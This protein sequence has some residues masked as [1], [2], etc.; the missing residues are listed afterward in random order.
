M[1]RYAYICPTKNLLMKILLPFLLIL[2]LAS[3]GASDS[4]ANAGGNSEGSGQ[5]DSTTIQWLDSTTQDLGR[6]T[7]GQVLDISWRFKN[8][9]EKPLIISDV[10]A[11]CGCTVAEKPQQPVAPGEEGV[12]KA[13]FDSNGQ[14]YS[15]H[16][17]VYVR[18]NNS[19]KNAESE[20][21]LTFTAEVQKQ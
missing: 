15:Q 3:C 6:I 10:R 2:V 16:K 17:N 11:G 13:R 19:N 7:E 4:G 14:L 5:A 1:A 8:T 21:V 20:D 12:I 9:G 18:A